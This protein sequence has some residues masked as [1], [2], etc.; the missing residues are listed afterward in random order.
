MK[1]IKIIYYYTQEKFYPFKIWIDTLDPKSKSDINRF[2]DKVERGITAC[3]EPLREKLFEIKA[4]DYRVFYIKEKMKEFLIIIGCK[5][6]KQDRTINKAL[7]Y[8]DDW[9]K[10]QNGKIN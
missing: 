3:C 5:K 2:I 9:R 6:D 4:N 1:K 7:E 8:A 10:R